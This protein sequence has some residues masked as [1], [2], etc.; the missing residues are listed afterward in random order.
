[1]LK[2]N[3]VRSAMLATFGS[4]GLWVQAEVKLPAIFSDNMVLQRDKPIAVWGWADEG[5]KVTV[6]LGKEQVSTEA[7]GG[8]WKVLLSKMNAGGPLQ[9]EV[10]GK[11]QV[12]FNDVLV[13]EVWICSG[14]S[15]MEWP[16][17]E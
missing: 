9:L 16:M 12:Q 14:Q 6:R 11:N 2:R 17:R 4:L 5:E 7:K 1:M 15:N 13:G 3:L 10:Q 8:K